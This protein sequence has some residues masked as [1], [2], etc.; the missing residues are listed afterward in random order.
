MYRSEI[1]IYVG[2]EVL[3]C[4]CLIGLLEGGLFFDFFICIK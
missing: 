1:S 3:S 4:I 2:G